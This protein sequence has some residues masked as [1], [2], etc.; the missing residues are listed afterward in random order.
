MTDELIETLQFTS[1][2]L[3]RYLAPIIFLFGV[4]GN[5]FNCLILSK[6]TLR[7]NPCALLFLVSSFIGLISMVAGLPT[8]ILAGWHHD[9]TNTMDW[10]CKTRV[11]MVFSTRT[12]AIWLIALATID[13]W[14]LSSVNIHRRQMSNLKNVKREIVIVVIVSII[15]YTHM[16]ICYKANMN[17]EPLKC[18]GKSVECRML[19][20]LVY[21]IITII[22]PLIIMIIFG[23]MIIANV[24]HARNR[25]QTRTTLSTVIPSRT[26]ELRIKKIDRHLL[27]MLLVQ[28]LLLTLFC[29]PQ[30]AQKFY[31]SL[32]PFYIL[33]ER[34]DAINIFLYNIEVILAFVASGMPFYV[35][36]ISGGTVFRRASTDFMKKVYRRLTCRL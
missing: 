22:I 25:I 26:E 30:A 10:A 3:N 14:F 8:R 16:I 34:E 1:D 18:Y 15:S 13:R 29:T 24:H 32:K 35:Y 12:M 19:T 23:L 20:D 5:T 17:D 4:V 33:S 28:V 2:Q 31:I 9:P 36:T 27:R 7:S 6:R 21:A 11:F